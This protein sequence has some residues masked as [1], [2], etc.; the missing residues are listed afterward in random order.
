MPS[1]TLTIDETKNNNS[2][3]DKS[4]KFFIKLASALIVV[5]LLYLAAA[6]LIPKS[7]D[8]PDLYD[9]NVLKAQ[10][11]MSS[12]TPFDVVV[13]GSSMASVLDIAT[14][15][16][17]YYNLSFSGGCSLTGLELIERKGA[18]T[19]EYPDVI[20]VEISD[21]MINGVDSDII[22]KTEGLG[23][24]FF[25]RL[26]NR[27]DY[28]FYSLV[29]AVY[30]RNKEKALND[31]GVVD[32]KIAYW[33]GVKSCPV[34]QDDMNEYMETAKGYVD[35]LTANGCR[36][37]LLELPNDASFYDMAEP[38]QV[39]ETALLYFPKDTYE[40]YMTDWSEYILSDGIHMGKLSAHIYTEKLLNEY[41]FSGNND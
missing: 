28:L 2:G 37:I 14:Y 18:S 30:Y 1:S 4:G 16:D 19:G 41:I 8:G 39:R 23:N 7:D 5:S 24:T 40:W 22:G 9:T 32:E 31:Y 38:V 33:A 10:R 13:T 34:N 25:G 26:D 21:S 11:Y 3:N 20:F 35:R 6:M 15:G 12:E 27:P 17:T 29:K 36:V